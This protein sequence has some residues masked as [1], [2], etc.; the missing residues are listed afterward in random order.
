MTKTLKTG[1]EVVVIAGA[2]KGQRGRI[3]SFLPAKNRV[4]VEGVNIRKKHEPKSQEN[5]E[6]SISEREAP[7]HRSNVMLAETYDAKAE[8][9]G[10]AA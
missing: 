2:H 7:L 4:I 6:G 5:P 3:L 1:D 10:G 8:K 9:R